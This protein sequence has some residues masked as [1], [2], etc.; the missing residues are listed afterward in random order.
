MNSNKDSFVQALNFN[1]R[2]IQEGHRTIDCPWRAL[3]AKT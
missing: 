3:S 1:Q 2:D